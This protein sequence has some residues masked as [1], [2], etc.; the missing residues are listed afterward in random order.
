[1]RPHLQYCIQFWASCYKKVTDA[2]GHVW[3]R[4]VKWVRCLEHKFYREWLKE[5][6]LFNL[7]KRRLKGDCISLYNYLKGGC[8]KV[9]V[10]LFS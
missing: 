9:G 6:R 4:A 10:G 5:L 2:L 3:R 7:E 8:G 1:M